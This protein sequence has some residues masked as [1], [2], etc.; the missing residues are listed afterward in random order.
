MLALAP[1][2]FLEERIGRD[3]PPAITHPE[4]FYGFVGVG[5]TWQLLFLVIGADPIQ[6][7]MAMLPAILEKAIFAISTSLLYAQNRVPA[8]VF[9]FS[10][11]DAVWGLLFAVSF[12]L[13]R[14]KKATTGERLTR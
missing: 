6:L 11:I 5:L 13:T 14:S 7:R 2:L 12:W 9:G 3:Y 1:Q 4:Y 10:M 8:V